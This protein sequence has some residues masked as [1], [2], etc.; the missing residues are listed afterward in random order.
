MTNSNILE[1]GKAE[2]GLQLSHHV[3][4]LTE[5]LVLLQTSHNNLTYTFSM[6]KCWK[7]PIAWLQIQEIPCR[8]HNPKAK[9]SRLALKTLDIR[10]LTKFICSPHVESRQD[11]SLVLGRLSSK[12]QYSTQLCNGKTIQTFEPTRCTTE[13]KGVRTNERATDGLLQWVTHKV[14]RATPRTARPPLWRHTSASL[15]RFKRHGRTYVPDKGRQWTYRFH[16][17]DTPYA[18]YTDLNQ[19][20]A[21][22]P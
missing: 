10:T 5:Y 8:V 12:S 21:W 17:R 20:C 1:T 13:N 6:K 18:Q 3:V 19:L 2:I 11:R 4:T 16:Y 7:Y 14:T 15:H 22:P 9:I